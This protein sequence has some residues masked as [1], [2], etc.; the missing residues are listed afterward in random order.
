V[1]NSPFG[2]VMTILDKI[3]EIPEKLANFWGLLFGEK[4]YKSVAEIDIHYW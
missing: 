3:H 1:A 4:S 2:T